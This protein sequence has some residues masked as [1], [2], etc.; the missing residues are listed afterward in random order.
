MVGFFL[1]TQRILIN[2]TSQI[3][4]IGFSTTLRYRISLK[5]VVKLY[6]VYKNM[7]KL[8]FYY[9]LT[10]SFFYLVEILVLKGGSLVQKGFL[11]HV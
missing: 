10:L 5:I 3:A 11:Q 6:T 2:F 1:T 7:C 8:M 9:F 4:I